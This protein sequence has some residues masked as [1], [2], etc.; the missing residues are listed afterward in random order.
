M[1]AL[2]IK[3]LGVVNKFLGFRISLDEEVGYALD[4]EVSIDLLLKE[5]GL[6]TS[7]GVRAPIVEEFNGCNSQEPEYLPVT[8]VNGNASVKDIQSLVKGYIG[9]RAVRDRIYVLRY[10]GYV[11]GTKMLKLQ[12]GGIG[13]SSG[14]VKIES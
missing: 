1:S 3:D 14:D 11:K 12:I 13:V 4:R 8:A 5:Y 6:E 2:E 10:T 7:N 9:S